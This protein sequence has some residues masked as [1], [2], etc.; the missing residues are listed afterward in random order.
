MSDPRARIASWFQAD[1]WL[2]FVLPLVLFLVIGS[3]EPTPDTPGGR[4]LGLAIDYSYY[5]WV[6]SAKILL[7]LG[8]LVAAWPAYR[9]LSVR[10]TP[11]GVLVGLVGAAAWIVLA[12]LRLEH[13]LLS[14]VGLDRF[15]LGARSAYDPFQHLADPGWAWTFLAVRFFGLVV[16]IAVAEEF[17]LRAW[18]M[19]WLV[20]E[21]WSRVPIGR[22]TWGSALAGTVFPMLMHPQELLAAAVWFSLVTWLMTRTRSIWDCVLAHAVTNLVL[23]LYAVGTGHWELL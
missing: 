11:W 4:I 22:I 7:T 8:A 10:L 15:A 20:D 17:F 2:P 9:T 3:L 14:L 6:Y 12:R 23:G 18:L 16:V 1:C 21:P 5:P 13:H 19:R